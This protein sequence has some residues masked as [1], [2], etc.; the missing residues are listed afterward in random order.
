MLMHWVAGVV[1]GM[2]VLSSTPA[3]AAKPPPVA[4]E[5]AQHACA[6]T[7]YFEVN[8]EFGFPGPTQESFARLIT[9]LDESET[10]GAGKLARRFER[11]PTEAAQLVQLGRLKSWCLVRLQLRCSALRCEGGNPKNPE[12]GPF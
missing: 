3:G 4:D 5:N 6:Q 9:L 12:A 11:A 2:L 7:R 10:K 8:E 1:V